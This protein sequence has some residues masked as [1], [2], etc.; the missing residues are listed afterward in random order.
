MTVWYLVVTA[1]LLV[2]TAEILRAEELRDA[3]SNS[4]RR[5]IV[6]IFR[7][8]DS[9]VKWSNYM[10]LISIQIGTKLRTYHMQCR[11]VGAEILL[12]LW[13][14]NACGFCERMLVGFAKGTLQSPINLS[15]SPA[16]RFEAGNSDSGIENGWLIKSISSS[17]L[18]L[19]VGGMP[20]SL[21]HVHRTLVQCGRGA[22]R[23]GVESP[24]K[25]SDE[26]ENREGPGLRMRKACAEGFCSLAS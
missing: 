3:E 13:V 18:A 11:N 19:K 14:Q 20:I 15:S 24:R 6:S 12:G 8:P 25:A 21:L 22:E 16:S 9:R 4:S 17:V 5:F 2:D 23:E 10:Y 1:S 7:L 26:R